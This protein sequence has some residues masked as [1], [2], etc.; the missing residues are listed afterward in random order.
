[1][2]L[3]HVVDPLG[4]DELPGTVHENVGLQEV[5]NVLAFIALISADPF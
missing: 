4:D 1:M 2:E 3:V 5:F